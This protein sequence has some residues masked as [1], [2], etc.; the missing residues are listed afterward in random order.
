MKRNVNAGDISKQL[1]TRK[2]LE[3]KSFKWFMKNVAFDL[4]DHY[5]S[6]PPP[7]Y[8]SGEVK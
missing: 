2:R 1:E 7:N 8:A 6:I 4:E 3:C 5:P